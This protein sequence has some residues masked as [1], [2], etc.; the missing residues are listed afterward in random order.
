MDITIICE[1]KWVKKVRE[2]ASK[3]MPTKRLM[4]VPLSNTGEGTPTHWMCYIMNVSEDL[5]SK[6]KKAE[7]YSTV[8]EG[9]YAGILKEMEL[10]RIR[11]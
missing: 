6:I 2:K 3:F 8:V 7:K 1:D 5:L 4:E 9:R 10:K 11:K